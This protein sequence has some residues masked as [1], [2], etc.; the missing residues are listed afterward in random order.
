MNVK[1]SYKF[2]IYLEN[3]LNILQN[4]ERALV[5]TSYISR[6]A[7]F[8]ANFGIV[9]ST[10]K[11]GT[12]GRKAEAEDRNKLSYRRYNVKYCIFLFD[13]EASN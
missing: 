3:L 7:N 1:L 2:E 6:R 4:E 10:S 5:I 12:V 8:V 9:G 11:S 13:R